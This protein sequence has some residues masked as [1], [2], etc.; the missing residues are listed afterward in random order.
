MKQ[1]FN[2][3][4]FPHGKPPSRE[5][6]RGLKQERV[7]HAQGAHHSEQNDAHYVSKLSPRMSKIWQKLKHMQAKRTRAARTDVFGVPFTA[8]EA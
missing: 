6:K 2:R 1:H 5:V 8:V 4:A 7:N 3:S